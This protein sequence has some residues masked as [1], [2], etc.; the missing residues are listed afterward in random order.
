MI[1]LESSDG[2]E[3]MVEKDVATLS[4]T[5]KN[6]LQGNIVTHSEET[7]LD[8][9][10]SKVDNLSFPNIKG[11]TLKKVLE[12][13]QYHF[14]NPTLNPEKEDYSTNNIIPWVFIYLFSLSPPGQGIHEQPFYGTA[15]R[16]DS[17]GS[18]IYIT[19]DI[20]VV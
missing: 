7:V 10:L 16:R 13:C 19:S 17:C 3:F 8:V 9:T 15:F 5:I 4:E 6:L 11:E 2:Q 18:S 14:E 20:F 12:W 1:T